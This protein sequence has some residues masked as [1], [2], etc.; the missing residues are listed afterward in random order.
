MAP[1]PT[2]GDDPALSSDRGSGS[3]AARSPRPSD[4]P[5]I[6][7]GPLAIEALADPQLPSPSAPRQRPLLALAVRLVA[8]LV[9]ATMLM[10]VKFAAE[11]GADVPHMLLFRQAVS[12]PILLGWMAFRGNLGRMRSQRKKAHA[13]RAMTGTIGM[14]LNFAA[15]ILL[16]LA[17]ATTLGFTTPIFAV[18]L[19]AILLREHV[20]V[21]RWTAV[22]LGFAGVILIAQPGAGAEIPPLGAAVAIAAAFMVALISIQIRDLAQTEDQLV[23]VTYFSAF[24]TPVL[25]GIA[26]LFPWPTDWQVYA[27]MLAIGVVGTAGQ[28][29]LTASLRMGRVS[30]VI[31]MDYAMLIWATFYGWAIWG[32]LP[33]ANLWLG[34]PLVIGAGAVIVWREHYLARANAGRRKAERVSPSA[35]GEPE[36]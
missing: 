1:P 34:A 20:G 2:P 15:P 30:S 14:L 27:L 11:R 25:L 31:V 17:V 8:G 9:L 22:L 12:L 26:L 36:L 10:L 21:W 18:I 7:A 35:H 5:A 24:S 3:L 4:G 33:P 13:A 6:A 23:I 19:S 16:P 29:L 28:V 32:R